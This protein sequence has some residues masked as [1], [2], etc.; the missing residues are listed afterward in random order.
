MLRLRH[1]HFAELARKRLDGNRFRRA[2]V[3][4]FTARAY[5]TGRRG[6]LLL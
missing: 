1:A 4:L 2:F 6:R 3:V 5:A